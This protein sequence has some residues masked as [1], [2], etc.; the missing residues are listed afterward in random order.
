MK[1]AASAAS[2]IAGHQRSIL[3]AP[4]E[5]GAATAA[6][7]LQPARFNNQTGPGAPC[8]DAT[9]QPVIVATSEK[10]MKAS[11]AYRGCT[12]GFEVSGRIA[13]PH[14]WLSLWHGDLGAQGPARA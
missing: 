1:V 13:I 2:A 4:R 14:A 7:T 9:Q 6:P 5:S 11:H 10:P 8:R 12:K 3:S